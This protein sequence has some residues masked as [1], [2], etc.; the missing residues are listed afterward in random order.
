MRAKYFHC[1][2]GSGWNEAAGR[3]ENDVLR[4]SVCMQQ[5][6]NVERV[7]IHYLIDEY[8]SGGVLKISDQVTLLRAVNSRI[9]EF[10]QERIVCVGEL[11]TARRGTAARHFCF[12]DLG[13]CRN[14]RICCR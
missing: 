9:F 4:E 7:H 13:P 10:E 1:V 2:W 6:V 3:Q 14:G 5:S 12:D 11:P 8:I